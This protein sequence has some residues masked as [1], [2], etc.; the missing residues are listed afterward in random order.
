MGFEPIETGESIIKV[1]KDTGLDIGETT[2][3]RDP[4]APNVANG[5]FGRNEGIE[6]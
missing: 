2:C 4:H 5:T 1:N 6:E 3:K